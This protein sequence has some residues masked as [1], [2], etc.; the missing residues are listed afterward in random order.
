M[1]TPDLQARISGGRSAFLF[2]ALAAVVTGLLLWF[3]TENRERIELNQQA[4]LAERMGLLLAGTGFDN[5]P[6]ADMVEVTAPDRLGSDDPVP[7]YRAR[8]GGAV[9]AVVVLSVAPDGYGGALRLMVAIDNQGRLLGVTVLE[10]HETPG[11]GDAFAAPGSR[12]LDAFRGR[13][14]AETPGPRWTL[15]SEGG[16]FDA[17]TG[18]SITPRAIVKAVYR[19]LEYYAANR[20]RLH[21]SQE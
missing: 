10:H 21:A 12:W 17:F 5:E 3:A 6:L 18:A 9:I 20:E 16:D 13:T 15:R 11:L 1:D 14:L 19:T 8:R 7:V 4:W 2:A